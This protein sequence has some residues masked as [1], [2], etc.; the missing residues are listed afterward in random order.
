MSERDEECEE[1]GTTLEPV[2]A[3]TVQC[4]ACGKKHP[5][6]EPEAMPI[7]WDLLR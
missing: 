4:P 2:D 7:S 1:C 5:R 6:Y 3:E